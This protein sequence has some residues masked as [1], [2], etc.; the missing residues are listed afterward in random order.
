M[1]KCNNCCH[2]FEKPVTIKTTYESYYGVSSEFSYST[3]LEID[4]CPSCGCDG[5]EEYDEDDEDEFDE[6]LEC[7]EV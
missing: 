2:I 5:I 3:S 1:Y 4:T 7:E 6:E